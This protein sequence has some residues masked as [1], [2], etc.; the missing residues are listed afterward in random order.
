MDR[1]SVTNNSTNSV[2][3]QIP[4]DGIDRQFNIGE[5]KQISLDE[6]QKVQYVPGGD[7]I[8][9]NCLTINDKDALAFLNM[10]VEPEY[11]YSTED[12]KNILLNGT[13]DEFEDFINFATEGGLDTAKKLAVDLQ[14]PDM[15]KRKMLGE[16]LNF[17]VNT[18]IEINEMMASEDA[19]VEEAKPTRKVAT[20]AET[21]AEPTPTRK[22]TPKYNVTKMG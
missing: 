6:L 4:E 16:K 22:T 21:A 10:E 14:I 17:N 18:A 2:G 15:R 11:F 19:P 3:Y 20:K 1:I 5:T 13:M 12:I 7:Y 9:K 8:L